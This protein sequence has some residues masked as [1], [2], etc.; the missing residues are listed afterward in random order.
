[1]HCTTPALLSPSQRRRAKIHHRAELPSIPLGV[2][3]NIL[4]L[5]LQKYLRFSSFL[6]KL[7]STVTIEQLALIKHF[8][9]MTKMVTHSK[10]VDPL[11]ILHKNMQFWI[12]K[13]ICF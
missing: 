6:V 7:L 13:K 9:W 3:S 12:F 8:L 11:Y 1:M 10:I 4:T 5:W 2:I